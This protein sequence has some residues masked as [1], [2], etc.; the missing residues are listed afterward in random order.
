[1]SSDQPYNS[2]GQI[3]ANGGE[4]A[5]G[6]AISRGWTSGQIALLFARRFDPMA[7]DD[8]QR[9]ID[10]AE[11]SVAAANAINA[12]QPG[13]DIDI[14]GVPI[15]PYLFGDEP[16]G[17]RGKAV[18][19]F[20]VDEGLHWFNFY[21]DTSDLSSPSQMFADAEAGIMADLAK[22]P[23]GGGSKF[24]GKVEHLIITLEVTERRF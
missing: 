17:K 21:H 15:N 5:L 4:I 2:L 12:Q 24:G 18:G 19:R 22:Y 23:E 13:D 9:L 8:R 20:S 11:R 1:M 14:E 16:G 7:P 6:L 3:L 10:L